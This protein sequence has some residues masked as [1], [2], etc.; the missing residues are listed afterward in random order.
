M[1]NESKKE[2]IS[3]L[4]ALEELYSS[5]D[6][7]TDS[8]ELANLDMSDIS[9]DEILE[10]SDNVEVSSL[11]AFSD[12]MDTSEIDALLA[13]D[14]NGSSKE[15]EFVNTNIE[16]AHDSGIS[17]DD[18]DLDNI[19]LGD[20]MMEENDDADE[21]SAGFYEEDI[22]ADEI[23]EVS[24]NEE[25]V[26]EESVVKDDT[27]ENDKEEE[28]VEESIPDVPEEIP[29]EEQQL[30]ESV[31]ETVDIAGDNTDIVDDDIDL[32]VNEETNEIDEVDEIDERS[33]DILPVS[34]E[35][36]PL[37]DEPK[38]ENDD[39]DIMKFL[40]GED[41]LEF[42]DDGEEGEE[43]NVNTNYTTDGRSNVQNNVFADPLSVLNDDDDEN[44]GTESEESVSVDDID[45]ILDDIK[46]DSKK[47]KKKKGKGFKKL[48]ANIVDEKEIEKA[49]KEKLEAEEAEKN[50][51]AEAER[52][53]LEAEEKAKLKEEKKAE[54]AAAK[55][56]AKQAKEAKKIAK[57]EAKELRALEEESE[58]EGR[59]NKAGAAIVFV[60]LACLGVFVFVGTNMFSYNRGIA[61]AKS[62]FEKGQYEESYNELSGLNLKEEDKILYDK[63]AT[64]MHV[65][66]QLDA[67]DIYCKAERYPQ[68][69]DALLKG[70]R[71]YEKYMPQAIE[72]DVTDSMETIK[73]QMVSE[74]SREY[75]ITEEMAR[76]INQIT[77]SSEYSL[78]VY[79]L[80]KNIANN[81]Y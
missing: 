30:E 61:A 32:S 74:L 28:T 10:A 55:E 15:L 52:K 58:I 67:Y 5:S 57:K 34:E 54:K 11:N 6:G 40:S 31:S 3:G 36:E 81:Y 65:Y 18:I 13:A 33:A 69:L 2:D 17:I 43:E 22:A 25:N 60:I 24:D 68:A 45:N 38:A 14:D 71:E 66:Q 39:I 16:G 80:A 49:N 41:E 29:E 27:V 64:I 42:L 63:V 26:L 37:K 70:I 19:S 9:I 56:A 78:R 76:E 59:I 48:F 50:K 8:E 20:L 1:A 44:D 62:Y 75:G 35:T 79:E 4:E 12:V 77:D 72:L 73:S 47:K 23:N 21:L 53:K 7:D 51:E 46:K